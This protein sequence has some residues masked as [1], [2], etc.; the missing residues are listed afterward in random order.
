M[1]RELLLTGGIGVRIAHNTH[2]TLIKDALEDQ[3]MIFVM[4]AN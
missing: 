4:S 3:I 2:V 1:L